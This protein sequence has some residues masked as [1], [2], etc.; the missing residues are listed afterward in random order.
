MS[1]TPPAAS[2]VDFTWA[3]AAAYMPPAGN[4]VALSFA[5]AFASVDIAATVPVTAA[6]ALA[7]GLTLDGVATVSVTASMLLEHTALDVDITLSAVVPVLAASEAAHGVAADGVAAVPITADLSGVHGVA[8]A[9]VATVPVQALQ[10]A[11]HGVALD[12]LAAIGVSAAADITV[13][14]YELRG[15]V[16]LSGVLVNRRVRAYSRASGAL[17]GEADTVVGRF[18]VHAGFAALECYVTPIDLADAATDWL[19][20]TANRITSVLALDTA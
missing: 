1:Y 17:L 9:A 4:E 8:V 20:P 11:V 6:Q 10:D 15:E 16:R 2:A 13:E 18:R 12:T 14:R 5:P 7:H 19:P 3:A